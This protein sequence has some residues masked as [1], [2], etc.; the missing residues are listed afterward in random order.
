M[1]VAVFFLRRP[2]PADI[3]ISPMET[4]V[5][6][7]PIPTA[8]PLPVEV[9]IL[10]AV[11]NPGVYQLPRDS[12]VQDVVLLAGGLSLNADPAGINLAE[13]IHDGQQL[14]VPAFGEAAPALPTPAV[15]QMAPGAASSG[16]AININTAD[17]E[18]LASLPGIGPVLAQRVVD[19]RQLNGPFSRAD[20]ITKVSGIGDAILAKIRDQITV[21]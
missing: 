4:A 5:P 10:G 1:G 18:T 21:R 13:R 8:T 14:F 2:V 6:P 11:E 20:D 15:A 19:Y 7:V 12:R 16:I 17:A 9:Y 3:V